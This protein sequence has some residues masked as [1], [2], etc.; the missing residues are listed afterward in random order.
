M[1]KIIIKISTV[2]FIALSL[3]ACSGFFDKDNTPDP[4]PLVK[5]TP[6]KHFHEDWY[7]YANFGIGSGPD[8]LR[9]VPA[10]DNQVIYTAAK[11]GGVTATNRLTGRKIWFTKTCTTLTAGPAADAGYVYV[12][13][14]DG[15]ILALNE[16]DGKIEWQ[17]QLASEILAPP[18]AK[19]GYVIAKTSNGELYA[20]SEHDGHIIWHYKQNEPELILRGG[21]T[22]RINNSSTV[23][24][25]ANGS[26]NKL[27]LSNGNLQWQEQIAIPEGSFAIQRMVD[28]DSNPIIS[29]G[30]VYVATYQGKVAAL[31][32]ASGRRIWSQDISS[33]QGIAVDDS[34]VYV[35]DARG[36]LWAFAKSNGHVDWKQSELKDRNIT[37][38]TIL[39]NNVIIADKLGYL[40]A[41]NANDGRFVARTRVNRFGVYAAPL[42]KDGYIYVVTKDGHL[43]AYTLE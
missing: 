24:G 20:L 5:F 27:H 13:T 16:M 29:G 38:P 42:V 12:G 3:S 18:A 9:L 8:Y 28:I 35:S 39:N 31:D 19:N 6:E 17:T 22:P 7:N 36:G 37:G 11:D 15:R 2:S 43:A 30:R 32:L 33:Y 26:L 4:T 41:L 34:R 14:Q 23:V 25:F 21:S 1:K 10:I 40:H